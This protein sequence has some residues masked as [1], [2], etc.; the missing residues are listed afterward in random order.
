MCKATHDCGHRMHQ[1]QKK[2]LREFRQD[3]K[4]RGFNNVPHDGKDLEESDKEDFHMPPL[5]DDDFQGWVGLPPTFATGEGDGGS[6][7]CSAE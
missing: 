5:T 2:S 6:D 7:T 1:L 4:D 3:R